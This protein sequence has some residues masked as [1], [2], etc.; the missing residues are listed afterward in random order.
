MPLCRAVGKLIY[1]AHV[2]KTAGT[3]IEHY[4]A[5]RFG[6][7][8]LLDPQFGQ[9]SEV[10]RW[11]QTSPQ[12]MPEDTRARLLPDNFID[13][14]FATVRHPATRLRSVFL[15]QREIAKTISEGTGFSAWLETIP[16]T[17][18]TDP[19]AY[20]GH[21]RTMCATVPPEAHVFQIEQGLDQIVSWLDKLTDTLDAETQMIPRNVL[22]KRLVF[23]K[24]APVNV[25]LN[26]DDLDRIATIYEGDYTRFGYDVVPPLQEPFT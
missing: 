23:E 1:Y 7:L 4:L 15:F 24:R 3:T 21:T 8:A 9:L 20:D 5:S 14:S 25:T 17:A 13:V 12:H 22:N 11:S 10:E 16:L 2:P 6:K 19:H 26:N 18:K